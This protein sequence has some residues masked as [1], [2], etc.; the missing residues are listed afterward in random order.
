MKG[1]IIIAAVAV[2]GGVAVL[3]L[4][5]TGRRET[6][7]LKRPTEYVR[8]YVHVENVHDEATGKVK[9]TFLMGMKTLDWTLAA[10]G[11]SADFR[12]R[13]PAPDGGKEVPDGLVKLRRYGPEGLPEL[14]KEAFLDVMKAHL[15]GWS[16]VDR[17][18][19]RTFEFLLAPDEKSAYLSVHFQLAGR[20]PDGSRTDLTATVRA[21]LV[22]E[23]E[24]RV[25]EFG[26]SDGFRAD[27][28]FP[29]FVDITDAAGFTLNTSAERARVLQD[30][31]NDRGMLARGGLVIRDMNGDGFPDALVSDPG[32]ESITFLN[33]GKGG[34][35]RGKA[36]PVARKLHGHTW[37]MTDLDND[38]ADEL[39]GTRVLSYEGGK[40]RLGIWRKA[41]DGWE[42]AAESLVFDVGP[43]D[44]ELDI[45]A[46]APYDVDGNGFMDLYVLVYSNQG[47]KQSR[48]NR[49]S[50]FDG[51][52]NYLFMNHGGLRFT[53]ESDARGITGTQYSYVAK[54]WD[55]DG[56]G[57]TDLFEGNDWGPNNFFENTGGAKFRK[58]EGHP[59][60][61]EPHYTMGVT[62]ADADNTGEWD[63][64]VSCM[65]SHAGNRIIPLAEG[66]S[67][68]LRKTAKLIAQGNLLYRR[69]GGAWKEVGV[70]AG[71]NWADWAWSC[72]FFDADND[73]DRDLFVANGF[74]T[75]EDP[76][77][78]DF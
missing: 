39:I 19:W 66:I 40:G 71:V 53:E 46:I 41:G 1:R 3:I 52:D 34:F 29:P 50:A 49:I 68:E 48:F 31:I 30:V 28:A 75:N 11:M 8:D 74:T 22:K 24:W 58:V 23:D 36:L 5:G 16:S 63:L 10:S 37:L 17:S 67:E 72:I 47:S 21:L 76:S 15:A 78:P 64:Y 51:A 9:K 65:Y 77:A 18:V 60:G 42:Q 69:S 32:S 73:R 44:R 55:F 27:C 38:G 2:A 20:R 43:M 56:D 70:D 45:S 59:F 57:D 26:I 13:F 54:F 62:L 7:F 14:K 6:E 33:D 12:G 25:R 61:T 4:V 35:V